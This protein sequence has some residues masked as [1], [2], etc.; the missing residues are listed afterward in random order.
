MDHSVHTVTMKAYTRDF[1]NV[2]NTRSVISLRFQ[3][4]RQ[5]LMSNNF[6]KQFWQNWRIILC[7]QSCRL[8]QIFHKRYFLY[9]A[10]TSKSRVVRWS[11]QSV[12]VRVTWSAAESVTTW[13]PIRHA[14]IARHKSSRWVPPAALCLRFVCLCTNSGLSGDPIHWDASRPTWIWRQKKGQ[15]DLTF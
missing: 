15:E 4:N 6:G 13:C 7:S 9:L 10:Y 11:G 12:Q 2:T 8:R 5:Q 14:L 1:G 3:F